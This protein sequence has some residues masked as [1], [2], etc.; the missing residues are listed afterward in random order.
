MCSAHMVH[1][2]DSVHSERAP[3]ELLLSDGAV[4]PGTLYV[5]HN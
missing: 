3:L 2:I 5:Y 4:E 1:E